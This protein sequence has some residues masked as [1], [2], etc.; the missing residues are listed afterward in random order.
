[1][2][3][4]RIVLHRD[5]GKL[6][7]M[8]LRDHTGDLQIAVSKNSVDEAN[9]KLAKLVDL[10]DIVTA[11]GRLGSTKTGEI[12]LWVQPVSEHYP[13]SIIH[14]PSSPFPRLQSYGPAT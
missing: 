9:F 3:S 6:V 11:A 1:M 5:I 12:T 8:T 7:F 13:S 14:H 4:G 10:G 2:V